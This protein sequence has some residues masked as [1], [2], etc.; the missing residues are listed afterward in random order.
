MGAGE[1]TP[2]DPAVASSPSAGA[3]AS[4]SSFC[5]RQKAPTTFHWYESAFHP[6]FQAD[7]KGWPDFVRSWDRL[8]LSDAGGEDFMLEHLS[9]LPDPSE[10]FAPEIDHDAIAFQAKLRELASRPVDDL[11]NAVIY[12]T[13][14]AY[15]VGSTISSLVYPV[16]E[17][18]AQDATLV[19]PV[20]LNWTSPSCRTRDLTCYFDSLPSLHTH[21][22]R[23]LERSGQLAARRGSASARATIAH[24]TKLLARL[25]EPFHNE[26][27]ESLCDA[28]KELG[29]GCPTVINARH[30]RGTDDLRQQQRQQEERE[31]EEDKHDDPSPPPRMGAAPS[32]QTRHGTRGILFAESSRGASEG[33]AEGG[34]AANG[35]SDDEEDGAPENDAEDGMVR[36]KRPHQAVMLPASFH[37]KRHHHHNKHRHHKHRGH[38]R[39]SS[40][41]AL[42]EDRPTNAAP[43]HAQEPPATRPAGGAYPPGAT[44]PGGGSSNDAS[45]GK[46]KQQEQFKAIADSNAWDDLPQS[47]RGTLKSNY[48][49]VFKDLYDEMQFTFNFD[50]AIRALR[51]D[52]VS[53]KHSLTMPADLAQKAAQLWESPLQLDKGRYEIGAKGS[54][55]AAFFPEANYNEHGLA[56]RLPK[57]FL[58]RG[59]FWLMSQVMHFLTTPNAKLKA[60][61][62]RERASMGFMERPILGLHVRKGDACGDRGECRDLK[63]YMPTVNKMIEMYGYKTVFLATPDGTVLKHVRKFPEVNFKFL[64]V[65]NTTRI[66][67]KQHYRK[68]DDAIAA[69]VV[70]AGNEFEEAMISA[71]L[72]AESD[73][74]IGGFSS[75]AARVAYSML[76]AGPKG[77]LKPY[78]SFDINW[79]GAFGKGGPTILRRGNESCHDAQRRGGKHDKEL[80]SLPCMISC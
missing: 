17:A 32:W 72:L 55:G 27:T 68:I 71:Y 24:Q 14:P 33:R 31:E 44:Q 36:G 10:L 51:Q 49:W 62:D 6:G 3:D 40:S 12:A 21:T 9:G 39:S 69:G 25:H 45:A 48:P 19:A 5:F 57:R 7:H 23:M 37:K 74:F 18:L 15:G 60:R 29:L 16:L 52:H 66:M 73:G 78:D 65:T 35:G 79:C 30:R 47:M 67:K 20:M 53:G 75:N 28:V 80:K 46:R 22:R 26:T 42:T 41:G 2:A 13:I 77:C 54:G 56:S 11:N 34:D 63:D 61:L 4:T 76:A 43:S 70:D 50:K 58:K 8:S 1:S 64:P 59:R 38:H